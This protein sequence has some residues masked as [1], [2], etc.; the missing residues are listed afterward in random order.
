MIVYGTQIKSDIDLPLELSHET[1]IRYEVELSSKVPAELQESITCG[2][3]LYAVHGRHVFLYSDR[4]FEGNQAGQPW[5]YEVKDVLRFYW[6]GGERTIYYELDEKGD[7]KLLSFWFIHLFLPLFMTLEDMYD[8][9]HAGAVEV[10]GKP[11]FF[12]APSMGGKSTMTDYFIKQGHIL[13]SDDKVPTFIDDGKFMAVGSHPYHRPYRKFEELGYRVENFTT[14]FKPIYT[15]Y[16]LEGVE[17]DAEII[18]EEVKGFAKFDALLP[19]YLYMFSYLKPK[20]LKYLSAMLNSI[21]VFHVKVPWNMK[22]LSE[23]HDAIVAH[24]KL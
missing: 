13:I 23:V 21:K 8:F 14:H 18:I 22:R 17:G 4:E 19:N 3:P 7:T 10:E 15:F 16:E 24:A 5:C 20:R 2:F 12:I 9:F 11:I 6:V 1:E